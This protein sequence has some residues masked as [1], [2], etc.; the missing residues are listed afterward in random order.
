MDVQ[1]ARARNKLCRQM[2]RKGE[3]EKEQLWEKSTK[4]SPGV[5]FWRQGLHRPTHVCAS[6]FQISGLVLIKPI[7]TRAFS[8]HGLFIFA[9]TPH[10][11]PNL[12]TSSLACGK[13]RYA[14]RFSFFLRGDSKTMRGCSI[15]QFYSP[16]PLFCHRFVQLRQKKDQAV[17]IFQFQRDLSKAVARP[18]SSG[19]PP[20]FLGGSELYQVGE[21]QFIIGHYWGA[22]N[23]CAPYML[24][25]TWSN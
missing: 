6:T 12:K 15:A 24:H 11:C 7:W 22:R 13:T 10:M 21:S 9:H 25:K 14:S 2:T 8:K 4:E 23:N 1:Q 16:H 5:K 17:L 19:D 3:E 18:L 20:L